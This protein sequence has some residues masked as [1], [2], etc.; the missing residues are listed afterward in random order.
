MFHYIS[1]PTGDAN[2]VP[3]ISLCV[4]FLIYIHRMW[5]K[6]LKFPEHHGWETGGDINLG[7][8]KGSDI[9]LGV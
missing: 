9:N 4:S 5:L 7:I 3:H 2:F 6:C 8:S 1:A